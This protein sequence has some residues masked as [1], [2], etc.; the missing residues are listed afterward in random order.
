MFGVEP[1]I[2]RSS[3]FDARTAKEAAIAKELALA[4][5]IGPQ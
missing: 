2:M 1:K 5:K 3:D 4:A